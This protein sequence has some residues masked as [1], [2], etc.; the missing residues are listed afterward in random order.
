M[1]KAKEKKEARDDVSLAPAR[2][3]R[4]GSAPGR[5]LSDPQ[6]VERMQRISAAH[7]SQIP[8]KNQYPHSADSSIITEELRVSD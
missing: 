4:A 3:A 1:N 6:W 5:L 8:V 7:Q 2:V